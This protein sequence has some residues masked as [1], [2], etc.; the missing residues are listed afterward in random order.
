[1]IPSENQCLAVVKV[2]GGFLKIGGQRIS[3]GRYAATSNSQMTKLSLDERP[4]EIYNFVCNNNN[5]S[6]STFVL[7]VMAIRRI[8]QCYL[9][10]I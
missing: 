4:T 8:A 6:V 10:S 5:M 1:M 2:G 9:S 7:Y 3:N